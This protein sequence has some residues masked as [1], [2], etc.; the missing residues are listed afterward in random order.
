[1][2]VHTSFPSGSSE[3]ALPHAKT[4]LRAEQVH[5]EDGFNSLAADLFAIRSQISDIIGGAEGYKTNV[6]GFDVQLAELQP[7]LSGS[8]IS[9]G[10]GILKV[11]QKLEVTGDADLKAALD[12]AAAANLASTLDVQGAATLEAGLTVNTAVAD[13]NAGVTANEIKIDGDT[14][15]EAG[16]LYIVGVAGEIVD[17]AKLVFDGSELA[18]DGNLAAVS[19]SF[20][21]DVTMGDL[22]AV[23]G[24]FSADLTAVNA[25][26]TGDLGAVSGSFSG[27]LT[28]TGDLFVNGA[29]TYVNTA[30]LQVTDKKVVIANGASGATLDGAG[31]YLGSDASVDESI[32]WDHADTKWIASDKFM[33]GTLQA[34][35][36][37]TAI[38]WA[39][40]DGNLVEITD[41]QLADAIE[42]RLVAGTGVSITESGAAITVAIGQ[43]VATTDS[44]TFAAVTGSNLTASRLMAS[45]PS[46]AMVSVA[47]L[48]AWVA[49]TA[50]QV[51][52]TDDLDG[53]I[54]LSLPQ[55]I[56]SGASPQFS[57]VFLD[58]N[59]ASDA[60]IDTDG[61]D[62]LV[63]GYRDAAGTGVV[64]LPVAQSGNYTLSG[65][66]ATSIVG[67]LN[68][69]KSAALASSKKAA[70]TN[71]G[72]SEIAAGTDIAGSVS[73][74]GSPATSFIS[75][76]TGQNSLVFVN[77]MLMQGGG[78][79]YTLNPGAGTLS[80]A[81]A[82]QV[83]DVVVI[84]KA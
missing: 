68:E 21:G 9:G 4:K 62:M 70:Y 59:G 45:D 82:L 13:F 42:A 75:E 19:G 11:K 83:G 30:N 61:S 54:T 41:Q 60:F 8:L 57:K 39:D 20:S 64:S 46:S 16:H 10:A 5:S 22:T 27:D 29:M 50:N 84:Q 43:P 77:G 44:V 18:I 51:T 66:T 48:T 67:A 25:T 80:F 38:V 36:L 63:L 79:D 71:T 72:A 33:A 31:I 14:A 47:D 26:L 3:P 12:V 17:E 76:L 52:V 49:G 7:H 37:S 34:G 6:S 2:A 69:L 58:G 74:P 81:F 28:V 40:S 55:D 23:N 65:F 32:R 53:S 78:L 1:M 73:W 56:H 15:A 24:A 35:D